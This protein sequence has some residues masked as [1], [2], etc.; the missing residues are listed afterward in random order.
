[1]QNGQ[2]D[3]TAFRLRRAKSEQ[4]ED[5]EYLSVNWLECLKVPGKIDQIKEVRRVFREKGFNL[6][7]RA[8]FAVL[9]VGSMREH[10][11][12]ECKK[13][14]TV[15]H[16]PLDDDDCHSGVFGYTVEDVIVADAIAEQIDEI[17]PA[18]D[19]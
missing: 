14:L 11:Q 16:L 13:L 10:V 8:V 2:V 19:D 15:Q 17:H 12:R 3:G 4:S 18:H 7:T 9:N 5:E 1:V 6:G